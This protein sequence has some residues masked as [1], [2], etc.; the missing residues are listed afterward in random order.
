MMNH[1]SYHIIKVNTAVVCILMFL[2]NAS[3]QTNLLFKAENAPR[4]P[5]A[6]YVSSTTG[7]DANDGLSASK[8]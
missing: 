4:Q 2:I 1:F 6:F 8:P 5:L 7:N 3:A